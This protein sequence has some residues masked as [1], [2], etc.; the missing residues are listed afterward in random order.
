MLFF[1]FLLGIKTNAD[2]QGNK[3]DEDEIIHRSV[4]EESVSNNMR[5]YFR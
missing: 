1:V 4:S 3:F 2:D 5:N